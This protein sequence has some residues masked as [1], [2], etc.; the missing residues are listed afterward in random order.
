MPVKP[1]PL[2]HPGTKQ[3]LKTEDLY[4]IFSKAASEQELNTTD[5]WIEIPDAVRDMYR[6]WRPTPLVPS[7]SLIADSRT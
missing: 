2:I 5:R 3:P 4:P 6:I 1:A 7:A